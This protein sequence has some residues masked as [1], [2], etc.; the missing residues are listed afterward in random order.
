MHAQ[1]SKFIVVVITTSQHHAHSHHQLFL[2]AYNTTTTSYNKS[3]TGRFKSRIV[4]LFLAALNGLLAR[5]DLMVSY[6]LVS[7]VR[8]CFWAGYVCL[9]IWCGTQKRPKRHTKKPFFD[10]FGSTTEI[11][12]T[13]ARPRNGDKKRPVGTRHV[14]FAVHPIFP[15]HAAYICACTS[16]VLRQSIVFSSRQ[17]KFLLKRAFTIIT[18]ILF[19]FSLY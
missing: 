14:C 1:A 17:W 12:P 19:W 9:M 10:L 6:W 18:F 2:S 15:I 11:I 13:W 4:N 3:Q 8:S 5:L 7:C 16:V